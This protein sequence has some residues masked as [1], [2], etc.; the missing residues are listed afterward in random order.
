MPENQVEQWMWLSISAGDGGKHLEH[1]LCAKSNVESTLRFVANEYGTRTLL[2][3]AYETHI[4]EV[5]S[6]KPETADTFIFEM[7]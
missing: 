1:Q 7:E 5:P 4:P 2:V 6:V 3:T